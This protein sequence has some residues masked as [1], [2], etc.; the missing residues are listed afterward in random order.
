MNNDELK[1][2]CDLDNI[3]EVVV[4]RPDERERK[5]DYI[6]AII[7]GV[8]CAILRVSILEGK[9]IERIKELETRIIDLERLAVSERL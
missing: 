4:S 7:D 1:K 2:K 5:R 6:V 8:E 9:I 3:K